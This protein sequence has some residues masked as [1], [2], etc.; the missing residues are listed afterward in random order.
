MNHEKKERIKSFINKFFIEEIK[1]LQD[2]EF[3]YFSFILIGQAI[4]AL[5]GLMDNKP[6]K[7]RGQSFKRFTKSINSLMPPKYRL[8][9]KDN[10]LYDKLRNQMTHSFIPSNSL[11]LIT[12]EKNINNYNHLDTV[13]GKLVLIAEDFYQDIVQA[14]NKLFYLLDTEKVKAKMIADFDLL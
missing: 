1:R 7:A 12:K 6:L 2:N 14:C 4:E 10:V 9:N 8:V 11:I 5:G 13:D 3:Y